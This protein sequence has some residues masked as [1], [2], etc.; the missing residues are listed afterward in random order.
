MTAIDIIEDKYVQKFRRFLS[1]MTQRPIFIEEIKLRS[2]ELKT[3]DLLHGNR[4]VGEAERDLIHEHMLVSYSDIKERFNEVLQ[5]WYGME[6]QVEDALDLY[7]S[8]IFNPHLYGH[9][10]TLFLAQALEVYHRSNPSFVGYVQPRDE[11]RERKKRIC[12]AAPKEGQWLNEKL[13]HANEKN[14]SQRL[15]DLIA[16]HPEVKIFIEN[17]DQFVEQVRDTRNHFTH[18]STD[19]NRMARIPD[20]IDQMRLTDNIRTLLE[21]CF[22]S[23]LGITGPP[24]N[25][26]VSSLKMR[27]YFD[28]GQS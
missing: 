15:K 3:C 21:V 8:T 13:G 2:T 18:Y 5:K 22:L 14:L 1:L 23:D 24:I 11:F 12:E 28:L 10:V 25:R 6:G 19:E 16:A 27:R 4:G 20:G 7:F 9:Q 26:L 17:P